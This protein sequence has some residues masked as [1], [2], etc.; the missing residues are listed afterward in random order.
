[1]WYKK[2]KKY[3]QSKINNLHNKYKKIKMNNT[4]NKCKKPKINNIFLVLVVCFIVASDTRLLNSNAVLNFD[5]NDPNY[6]FEGIVL[7]CSAFLIDV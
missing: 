5:S 1:M 6:P 4:H 7:S 2:Y 3:K